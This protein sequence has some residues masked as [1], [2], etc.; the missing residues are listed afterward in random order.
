M[1][2]YKQPMW[3]L[4]LSKMQRVGNSECCQ[5]LKGRQVIFGT[6]GTYWILDRVVWGRFSW[7]R[8]YSD[9]LLQIQVQRSPD[10]SPLCVFLLVVPFDDWTWCLAHPHA[11]SVEFPTCGDFGRVEMG[12][13]LGAN[14]SVKVLFCLQSTEKSQLGRR[15]PVTHALYLNI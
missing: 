14:V 15:V 4:K 5:L 1:C 11:N 10:P 6:G 7:S 2:A 8:L 9:S 12:F 3:L 13:I